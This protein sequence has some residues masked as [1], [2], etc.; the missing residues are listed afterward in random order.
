M[1]PALRSRSLHPLLALG[2][3]P[4]GIAETLTLYER[5]FDADVGGP[6]LTDTFFEEWMGA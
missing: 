1:K 6:S 4:S 3:K 5:V 2:R